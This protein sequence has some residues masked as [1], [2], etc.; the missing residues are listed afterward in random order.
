MTDQELQEAI[1]K[2]RAFIALQIDYKTTPSADLKEVTIKYIKELQ[3]I[4][5]VRA[6]MATRPTVIKATEV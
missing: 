6:G 3:A 4:Q 1:D 2:A 5:V